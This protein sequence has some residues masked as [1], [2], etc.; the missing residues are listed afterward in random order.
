MAYIELSHV[1]F[2]GQLVGVTG[3]ARFKLTA[4]AINAVDTVNIAGNEVTFSFY[5]RTG[6]KSV[7]AGNAIVSGSINVPDNAAYVEVVCYAHRGATVYVDGVARPNRNRRG[8]GSKL[9]PFV[10]ILPLTKGVHSISVIAGSTG[11]SAD[12]YIFC[13]YIRRTGLDNS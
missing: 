6:S 9:L 7:A 10:E 12:G 13:R 5:F 3:Q 11:T 1:L 4:N 8:P 2:R